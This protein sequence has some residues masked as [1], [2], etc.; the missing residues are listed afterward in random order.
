MASWRNLSPDEQAFLAMVQREAKKKNLDLLAFVS[1]AAQTSSAEDKRVS[2]KSAV[3]ELSRAK[4]AS[5]RRR[6]YVEHFEM[7]LRRFMKGREGAL[8]HRV[9][10]AEIDL[11]LNGIPKGSQRN[12]RQI[13]STFFNFARRRGW[14]EKN[15]CSHLESVRY[16]PTPPRVFSVAELRKCLDW[17]LRN[18]K[19]LAWF[20]L[21]T[22]AGLRPE[23]AA[24]TTW[25]HVHFKEGLIIVDS[26]TSKVAQ[27]RIVYASATAFAWL[28]KAKQL[29]AKLPLNL[30]A[31]RRLYLALRK[32]LNWKEWPKDIT[33]HS[34]ASYWL[35]ECGSA[36]KVAG[37]LGHSID[38]FHRHYKALVTREEAKRFWSVLP[39]KSLL[40]KAGKQS[41]G[42]SRG[43]K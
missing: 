34:A 1:G 13:L 32:V 40:K 18:P 12:W 33:R 17:F 22:F 43:I 42:G 11:F 31:R 4:L 15:P 8:V 30:P 3:D 14:I 23:E 41:T 6:R 2:L 16:V 27:R 25:K 20:A 24:A 35:A 36:E 10:E 28:R 39:T 26:Q 9:T 5:G 7:C 19:G 29:K 21:T 37:Q 38:Q